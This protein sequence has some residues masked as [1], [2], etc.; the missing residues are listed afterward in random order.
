[1]IQMHTQTLCHW[2][3]TYFADFKGS[4]W[5]VYI[6]KNVE[7]VLI[8]QSFCQFSGF[9]SKNVEFVSITQCFSKISIT[10]QSLTLSRFGNDSKTDFIH[11]DASFLWYFLY[12]AVTCQTSNDHRI[13]Y[14]ATC[15]EHVKTC[16]FEENC[17][18]Y[19]FR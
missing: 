7:F 1:M 2:N 6:A 14:C 18:N 11:D 19:V 13:S 17:M 16:N 15:D 8:A 3:H 10:L 9:L 4:A 12:Y 5:I